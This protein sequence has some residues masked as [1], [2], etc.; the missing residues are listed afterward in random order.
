MNSGIRPNT[1]LTP[2]R[3]SLLAFPYYKNNNEQRLRAG[4]GSDKSA[5][6][7][8]LVQEQFQSVSNWTSTGVATW[9]PSLTG[10]AIVGGAGGVYT[11]YMVYDPLINS[12]EYWEQTIL[13]SVTT[14]GFGIGLKTRE[15][16]TTDATNRS[17]VG[18]F[19]ATG[20]SSGKVLI[21]TCAEGGSTFGNRATSAT[22]ITWAT[23]DLLRLTFKRDYN[24]YT[25][26]IY[27]YANNNT[28]SCSFTAVGATVAAAN[29]ASKFGIMS[30]GGN[31][32]VTDYRVTS[33]SRKNI[34]AL[35]IGDSITH[36]LK[37]SSKGKRFVDMIFKDSVSTFEVNAGGSDMTA[38]YAEQSTMINLYNAQ[39]VFL[40]IGGND[41]LN[42]VATATWQANYMAIR[43]NIINN[44]AIPIHLFPTARVS[45]DVGPLARFILTLPDVFVQGT[46]RRTVKPN[47]DLKAIYDSGDGV[48]MNDLGH[49]VTA[50][51]IREACPFL[52]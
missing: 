31:Q 34:K 16:Q 42:G 10:L 28:V 18:R 37:G 6:L 5:P 4:H 51:E 12:L 32:T 49:F 7:G 9:T 17:F 30:F 1:G 20:A 25:L 13:F 40:M 44:G 26:T 14:A 24:I 8:L 38:Q 21:D 39:Y 22:A 23:N 11:N 50:E 2:T 3:D 35:F 33:T 19:V 43:N 36:G 47:G 29:P 48:H 41:I 52:L 27:N 45:T 15:R 46:Y